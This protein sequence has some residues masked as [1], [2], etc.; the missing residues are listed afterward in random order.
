MNII[1]SAIVGLLT[2]YGL[3]QLLYAFACYMTKGRGKIQRRV[4]KLV[5]VTDDA[6]DIE[7]YIRYLALRDSDEN[8]ILLN[9]TKDEEIINIMRILTSEFDFVYVMTPYEYE[10]YVTSEYM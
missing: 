5:P 3:F 9:M 4:H 2:A 10:E 8:V 1:L 6:K 7:G